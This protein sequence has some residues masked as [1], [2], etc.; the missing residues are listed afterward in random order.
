MWSMS[1]G[2]PRKLMIVMWF[3]MAVAC[4]ALGWA[5]RSLDNGIPLLVV[6]LLCFGAGAGGLLGRMASGIYWTLLGVAC[7][8]IVG[9]F[10][11]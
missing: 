4:F 6:A 5:T 11:S 7:V 2:M 1:Q 10:L 8:G 3:G 9:W